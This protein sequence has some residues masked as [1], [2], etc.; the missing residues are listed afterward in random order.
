M[1]RTIGSFPRLRASK[2][3][4]EAIEDGSTSMIAAAEA[5]ETESDYSIML[6]R[7]LKAMLLRTFEVSLYTFFFNIII[8]SLAFN[9]TS[10]LR[11]E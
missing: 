7:N 11:M 9:F 8:I 10:S 2:P 4:P 3:P 6:K 5:E 1:F